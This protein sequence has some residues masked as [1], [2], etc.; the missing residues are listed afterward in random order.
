MNFS[1]KT[2]FAAALFAS[3][4]LVVPAVSEDLAPTRDISGN[5]VVEND[6]AIDLGGGTITLNGAFVSANGS[7]A[8]QSADRYKN[9]VESP[10]LW[11]IAQLDD[12]GAFTGSEERTDKETITLT[13]GGSLTYTGGTLGSGYYT[14]TYQMNRNGYQTISPT[15]A[16]NVWAAWE[17][18][19]SFWSAGNFTGKLVV[20]GKTTLNVQ[21]QLSQFVTFVKPTA[22]NAENLYVNELSGYLG[23]Q[24]IELKDGATLSF[25]GSDKNMVNTRPTLTALDPQIGYNP[26]E[27][28]S[29]NFV[30]NITST[31]DSRI[32]I[33]NDAGSINRI[34]FNTYTGK[35]STVGRLVGNGRVYTTGNGTISFIGESELDPGSNV[36]ANGNADTTGNT[37]I[38]GNKLADVIL[39]TKTVNVGSTGL[40]GAQ[41]VDNV[42]ANAPAV[43]LV[44][45]ADA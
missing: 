4:A 27:V 21:G 10:L 31:A 32:V 13:G 2:L 29:L 18:M 14:D 19:D 7:M 20:D 35:E 28:L 33:G 16:P 34:V 44:S 26:K 8:E 1:K 23:I 38:P 36:D 3:S 9:N 24:A 43:H 5:I 22:K 39:G 12:T 30:N 17:S 15:A 40:V 45:G 42:F 41:V 6:F 37:W 25:A 11:Y